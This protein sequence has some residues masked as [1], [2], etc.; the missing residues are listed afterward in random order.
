MTR[1]Q[2]ISELIKKGYKPVQDVVIS[3]GDT[4]YRYNPSPKIVERIYIIESNIKKEFWGITPS[5]IEKLAK[6]SENF[7]TIFL[8]TYNQKSYLVN[9]KDI[10]ALANGNL[11]PTLSTDSKGY[12]KVTEEYMHRINAIELMDDSA[13]AELIRE[14]L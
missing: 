3:K 7:F 13:L 12:Y 6:T 9:K 8:S 10:V 2:I 4:V 1:I 14:Q 11:N 5:V